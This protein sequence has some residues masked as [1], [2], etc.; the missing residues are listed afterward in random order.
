MLFLETCK[1]IYTEFIMALLRQ[2]GA[3]LGRQYVVQQMMLK[4]L[5][6]GGG[7]R[8]AQLLLQPKNQATPNNSG[9]VRGYKKFGHKDEPTPRITKYFHAFVGTLFILTLLDWKKCVFHN[10]YTLH[11]ILKINVIFF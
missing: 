9:A 1:P 11:E 4:S 2:C 5:I 8:S 3:A 10:K 7:Q 6:I